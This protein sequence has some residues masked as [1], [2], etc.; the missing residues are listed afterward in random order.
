MLRRWLNSITLIVVA[1]LA[2][3]SQCSAICAVAPCSTPTDCTAHCQQHHR[4]HH[5]HPEKSNSGQVCH[6][7]HSE[8]LNAESGTSLGKLAAINSIS[9]Q[10]LAPTFKLE[11]FDTRLAAY[12]VHESALPVD[13]GTSVFELL[14]TFRI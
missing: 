13:R 8:I 7:Q 14:S 1:V 12:W 5:S 3:N 11:S 4:H 10:C 2:L 6:V 9:A